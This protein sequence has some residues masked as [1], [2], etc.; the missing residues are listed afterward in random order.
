MPK[1]SDEYKES[2]RRDI[3]EAA[4]RAFE[5][6]GFQAASMADIIAES[7]ASAGAIYGAYRSKAEIV[8]VVATSLVNER[9]LAGEEFIMRDPLPSPGEVVGLMMRSITDA[10][11]RTDILVQLW[12]EAI[13]DP[14]L[15]VITSEIMDRI[16]G[17]YR[18]YLATWYTQ[19]RG[20][21][22]EE[23]QVLAQRVA[24]LF[25]SMSQG[26]IIQSAIRAD[27][28]REAYLESAAEFLPH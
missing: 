23:S 7:G 25:V 6:K 27:F 9:L 3:A 11:S 28:D 20:L 22:T 18:G 15:K 2:K 17:A 13:T 4:M 21:S 5:R 8:H 24:P 26:Y 14:E 1:V 16:E 10:I 19:S 12:G